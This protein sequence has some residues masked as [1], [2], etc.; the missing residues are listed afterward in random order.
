MWFIKQVQFGKSGGKRK[1]KNLPLATLGLFTRALL[2]G[3]AIVSVA[4]T[5]AR[6]DPAPPE[7][8]TAT[9]VDVGSSIT[10]DLFPKVSADGRVVVGL[11]L[12]GMTVLPFTWIDGV[13]EELEGPIMGNAA[14]PFATNYDGSVIVGIGINGDSHQAAVRW[15]NGVGTFLSD[16]L[17]GESFALDVSYDGDVVVGVRGAGGGAPTTA[18]YW[19][20]ASG[21]MHDIPGFTPGDE[22]IAYAVSGNGR[23]V[24]GGLTSGNQQAFIWDMDGALTFLGTYQDSGYPTIIVALTYDGSAGAAATQIGGL[25]ALRWTSTGGFEALPQLPDAV[26]SIARD[27]S[28]SGNVIVGEN[29]FVDGMISSSVAYRWV[30]GVGTESIAQIL[31]DHDVDIT[32]WV[33]KYAS[34]ISADGSVVV[35]LGTYDDETRIYLMT[36]NALTTPEALATSLAPV[37]AP[38]GQ[39]GGMIGQFVTDLFGTGTGVFW[40]SLPKFGY[41]GSGNRPLYAANDT[42]TMSDASPAPMPGTRYALYATGSA[43]FGK[44]DGFSDTGLR[45]TTGVLLSAGGDVAYGAG[46]VGAQADLD[47]QYDGSVRNKALGGSA[48]V[49]YEPASGLRLYGVAALARFDVDTKR[50]YLNGVTI[51]QSR[52]S[53]D[54]TGYALAVRGGYEFPLKADV[55]LMPYA[56]LEWNKAKIDGYTET[57]GGIPATVGEQNSR[58]L[59]SRLGAELSSKLSDDTKARFRAAWGHELSGD[60]GAVNVTALTIGYSIPGMSSKDDWAEAGATLSH[61][62]NRNLTLTASVDGRFAGSSDSDAG[63]TLG[64][65]YRLN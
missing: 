1:M 64:L 32:G 42:G 54:G 39:A 6:A 38:G 9:L 33:F 14:Y 52:G 10:S 58:K 5:V 24:A 49:S 50:N 11:G 44:L 27:I 37:G 8:P 13:T 65:V 17:G 34:G 7:D 23:F 55:S 31:T 41:N 63:V 56:E 3:T 4:A 46:I 28:D 59:I 18:Y 12:D 15:V 36:D 47:T 30:N 26:G 60:D 61:D 53:T 21:E 2:A 43:G 62:V 29:Y 45:G 20:T 40:S 51:D 35:G 16:D 48:L 25:T 22:S 19:T 57:G